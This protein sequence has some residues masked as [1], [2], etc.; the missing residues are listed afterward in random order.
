MKTWVLALFLGMGTVIAA[1]GQQEAKIEAEPEVKVVE[2][3]IF[4]PEQAKINEMMPI[5]AKV[6]YGD[7][8]VEDA[9]VTFELI[10]GENKERIEAKGE[11]KGIYHI[12]KTFT[13][14]GTYEVIAHTNAKSMHT[15]PKMHIQVGDKVTVEHEDKEEMKD[16]MKDE[17]GHHH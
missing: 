9:E 4:A 16:E 15:M 17:S 3:E 12:D 11:G 2:V 7:E 14:E 6:T 5:E 1:C 10:N 13:E 8:L